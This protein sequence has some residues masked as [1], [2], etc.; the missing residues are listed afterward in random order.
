MSSGVSFPGFGADAAF[1][2]LTGAASSDYPVANLADLKR[3]RR[4]FQASAPG[5]IA[6][7]FVLA[8][9]QPVGFVGLVH[10]NASNGA[11]YRVRLYSDAAMTTLVDDSGTLTFSLDPA[12]QFV[13][14]TPYLPPAG[15]SVRAGRVDLSALT[16]AWQIGGLEIAGFWAFPGLS[17]RE[18]GLQTGDQL[19]TPIEGVTHATRQFSPR[20]ITSGRSLIDLTTDGLT[21]LDFQVAKGRSE[22]FVWLRAYE[23][24]ASWP[25]EA[26]LVRNLALN[27]LTKA[28]PTAG[29]FPLNFVEHLR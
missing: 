3:I 29:Q 18:R 24:A 2:M 25:R 9:N 27:P 1:A 6:V 19:Q 23:D 21:L 8:A 10:H 12:S 7:S 22:P 4:V 14:V 28:Q 26:V 15:L 13:A 5:A 17:A 20:I 16:P 11:T